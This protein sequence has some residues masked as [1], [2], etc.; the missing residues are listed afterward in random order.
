MSEILCD[1]LGLFCE[2]HGEHVTH[3]APEISPLA[4]MGLL[5]LVLGGWAI[6]DEWR[7]GRR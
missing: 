7:R 6:L 1:A 4:L 3:A 5:V 2:S